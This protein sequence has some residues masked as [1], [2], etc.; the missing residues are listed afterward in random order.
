[1]LK[2]THLEENLYT[3][4]IQAGITQNQFVNQ[5]FFTMCKRIDQYPFVEATPEKFDVKQTLGFNLML[6]LNF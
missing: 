1:M 2:L 3:F 6:E 5:A 4:L